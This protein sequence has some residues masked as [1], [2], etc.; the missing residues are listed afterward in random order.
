MGVRFDVGGINASTLGH[1]V[2]LLPY[3]PLPFADGTLNL[4][5]AVSS[6]QSQVSCG[7]MHCCSITSSS[8]KVLCWGLN[9][10]GQINVPA[11]AQSDQVAITTG[12][13]F[14]CSLSGVTG[15]ITC[16]GAL[17]YVPGAAMFGVAMP[18]AYH[19]P[20]CDGAALTP[21]NI[22][23]TA[24]NQ[25]TCTLSLPGAVTC[26]GDNTFGQ[27]SV[28][29]WASSGQVGVVAGMYHT[30][31]LA[32]QATGGGVQC[33]GSTAYGQ[34][35]V[36]VAATTSQ[37]FIAAG[38]YHTMSL[39]S[40]ALNSTVTCW[41]LNDVGRCTM[42]TSVSQDGGVVAIAA[43]QDHS[44]ALFGSGLGGGVVCWGSGGYGA[45]W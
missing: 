14:S 17:T 45:C 3:F 26:F 15:G 44:C 25:F 16:W 8:G 40:P 9:N 12:G 27:T 7:S 38:E 33:F 2:H 32:T 42:P 19:Q 4:P 34:S 5:S 21:G 6:G 43:G 39:S 13:D 1:Y 10:Q 35:S 28:P 20:T 30:C 22:V 36:P 23:L 41:G 29:S 31:T 18:C 37:T 11:A 24:G